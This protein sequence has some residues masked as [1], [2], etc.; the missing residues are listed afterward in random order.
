M[1]EADIPGP[2]PSAAPPPPP[3][4]PPPPV[5]PPPTRGSSGGGFS[6][7][8]ASNPLELGSVL[9][10][11]WEV[12]VKDIGLHIGATAIYIVVAVLTCGLGLL[13]YLPLIAGTY[14]MAV[15]ALKGERVVF[16]DAFA[17]FKL[18]VPLMLMWLV[19][20]VGITLGLVLCILPG[21][22]LA[23]AWAFAPILVIDR[24]MEFWPAME[25]SMKTVN[26]HFAPVLIV[27]L[28]FGVINAVGSSTA[29]GGLITQPFMLIGTV[30][31]YRR[32]FGLQSGSTIS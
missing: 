7:G 18:F 26:Q 27:L 32:L 23:I 30:V 15:K 29:L 9:Q 16:D 2:P 21:I 31:A 1:S 13:I 20:L 5:D 14:I 24:K 19:M 6:G 4:S 12:F 22:Y 11:T 17:G 8:M 3:A 25:L 28:V 10:E